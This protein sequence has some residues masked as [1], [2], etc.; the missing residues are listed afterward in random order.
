[1]TST[2]KRG[3]LLAVVF[4]LVVALS[5]TLIVFR[6]TTTVGGQAAPGTTVSEPP[7]VNSPDGTSSSS[8]PPSSSG[9]SSSS[10]GVLPA[11]GE[12]DGIVG[13]EGAGDPYYP[14]AGNSGYDAQGYS[15]VLTYDP[16]SGEL[17]ATTTITATV[18]A[19]QRLGRFS[20]DLQPSL[21]VS[22]VT[23]DGDAAGAIQHDE[24]LQITP[25]TGINPGRLMTV[26]VTYAGKP[27]LIGGGTANVGDGGWYSLASGGSVAIGEPFG[28]STWYPVNETPRDRAT[29]AVEATVPDGWKVISNGL[30]VD[31]TTT[32]PSGSQTFGW[33]AEEP[34][35]SYLTTIYIDKFEQTQD[36]ANGITVINAYG[37]GASQFVD[38][39]DKTGDYLAFL[40][41]V[42]GAY[43]FT[44]SGGVY[45]EDSIGFALET[46]TRPVYPGWVDETTVVHELAHQW[47]GDDVTVESW[48]DICMNECFAS[49]AEWLWA[50]QNGEDLDA[51]YRSIVDSQQNRPQWWDAPLVDMGAGNE[52]S[53]VYSRGPLALHALRHEIGNEKFSELLL[54]WIEKYGGGNASFSQFEDLVDQ[55]AGKDESA[56]MDAWFRKTG[57]PADEFL[58]PGDLHP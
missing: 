16:D 52:F 46:Q 41:S 4:A 14:D 15:V 23:V 11:P 3:I 48:S 28:A 40:S 33:V 47:F 27:G 26:V 35:A 6:P 54:S 51:R 30:P 29:F 55:I 53:D 31:P 45:I 5:V 49:Y 32:P 50:E 43:P 37:P 17:E 2:A 25:T 42:F 7:P 1:M 12:P 9:S 8:A 57:V 20:F 56:F 34:M 19:D 39:G 38:L 36:V 21:E 22:A 58:W 44:A 10:P 18:T 24:K 13:D